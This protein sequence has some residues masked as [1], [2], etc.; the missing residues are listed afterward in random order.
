MSGSPPNHHAG[1]KRAGHP[2]GARG[3]PDE[4]VPAIEFRSFG[5]V[6]QRSRAS[7]SDHGP[8]PNHEGLWIGVLCG[9]AIRL[10]SPLAS[11]R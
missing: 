9:A 1:E 11:P 2:P 3:F 4:D 8:E 7:S 10:E 5:T 6:T